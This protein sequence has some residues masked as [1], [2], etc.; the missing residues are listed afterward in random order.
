MNNSLVCGLDEAGR[1]PVLGPL[2]LCGVCFK[3]SKLE[4]LQEI[5]VKDSKR[6]SSERRS[7]L[8]NII[9]ENC[10]SF[11]VL[12][13]SPQEIDQ[14]IKKRISL[15]QLELRKFVEIANN[16]KPSKIYIDAADTDEKRFGNTLKAKLNYTPKTII[17]KH[18]ADDIYPIVGAASIIA[19]VKRDEV[20]ENLK[21]KYGEIGSG[22]PSDE[23]TTRF[24][25]EWIRNE[26]EP[27]PFA[28][29]S[30]KTTKDILDKEINNKKI[31][32]YL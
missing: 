5:G 11:K 7:K 8:S 12:E 15:N 20:I 21:E 25:R 32:Q 2:V 10:C 17:S 13:L 1:G 16:L 26:K 30:W 14:R 6:L 24:L 4:Y 18:K 27:P 28:R 19:K 22:Y 9:K 23:K 29:L 31:T 3:Q